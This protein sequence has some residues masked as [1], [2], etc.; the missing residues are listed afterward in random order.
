[1]M[2]KPSKRGADEGKRGKEFWI[3][4]GVSFVIGLVVCLVIYFTLPNPPL[5]HYNPTPNESQL[6]FFKALGVAE[7]VICAI[8]I[9]WMVTIG[10]ILKSIPSKIRLKVIGMY[11]C[12]GWFLVSWYPHNRLHVYFNAN[13]WAGIALDFTFHWAMLFAAM[14]LGRFI[15]RFLR[16]ASTYQNENKFL[17]KNFW[18]SDTFL[19]L[20]VTASIGISLCAGL[21]RPL[22]PSEDIALDRTP[23]QK[24]CLIFI[25]IVE[26]F[27]AGFGFA[28]L[29]G[30][31]YVIWR[32]QIT[33]VR[34]RSIPAVI[35]I[36]WLLS[37][38][39][40]HTR[41][42]ALLLTKN[43]IDPV[44][45][46]LTEIFFHWVTVVAGLVVCFNIYGLIMMAEVIGRKSGLS[47]VSHRSEN[48]NSSASPKSVE[49]HSGAELL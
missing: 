16:K 6:R 32:I 12:V 26:S 28:F 21:Q 3:I 10:T 4:A 40:F 49:I 25:G 39:W 24:G 29:F 48:E 31:S 15:W 5:S 20:V 23:A 22:N 1:M 41:T 43:G 42:H 19:V 33:K 36:W 17:S 18:K 45:W 13:V 11:I 2:F 47:S 35:S 37:S 46:I 8:G 7:C 44:H 14:F 30:I 9:S 34:S 27:F 38:W